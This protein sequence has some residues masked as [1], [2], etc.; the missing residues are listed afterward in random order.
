MAY[1]FSPLIRSQSQSFSID[2]KLNV[3]E[4]AD[5]ITVHLDLQEKGRIALIKL[6]VIMIVK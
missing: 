5:F 4:I 2:D 3:W 1:R 6:V